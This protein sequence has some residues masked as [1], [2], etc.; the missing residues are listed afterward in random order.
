MDVLR[1]LFG[2]CRK[3][4]WEKLCTELGAEYCDKGVWAG[5][6][7]L[8]REEEWTVTLDTF[9]MYTGTTNIPFTR[10]RAPYVNADG[11]RFTVYREGVF[12]KIGKFFGMQ[13][14]TVG[15]PE[16][17]ESFII[18]GTDEEKLRSLFSNARMRDLLHALP[19]VL[20]TVKDDEGWFGPDFPDG[21][22]ELYL[23]TVGVVKEIE[24]L[25][26][27]FNL[28]SETL[29]HLC[30]IGSAYEDDPGLRLE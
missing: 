21:V 4:V 16:F 13:D 15:H 3:D 22:D 12:S 23:H 14:V 24:T 25:R 17:D 27:L 18:K 11:F 1:K 8:V 20:M 9:S 10:L 5:D 26:N 2:P 19:D 7:V 28:F 29:H 30:H 6:K